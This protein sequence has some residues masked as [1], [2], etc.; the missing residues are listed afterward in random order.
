MGMMQLSPRTAARFARFRRR[1]WLMIGACFA[2]RTLAALAG[3]TDT[4]LAA[5]GCSIH[6]ETMPC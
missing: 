5:P 2:L 4:A 3:Q 1:T 6:S